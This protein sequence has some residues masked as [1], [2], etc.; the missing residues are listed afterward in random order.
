MMHTLLVMKAETN[1]L[2]SKTTASAVNHLE[3]TNN[4]TGSNPI[5]AAVGGD[6]NVGI[7]T[8]T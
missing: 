3:I 2:Y 6:D 4:A 8:Y 1:S 5:L 7:A